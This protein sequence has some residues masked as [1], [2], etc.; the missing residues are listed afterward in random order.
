MSNQKPKPEE[1]LNFFFEFWKSTIDQT[2]LF[3]RFPW[4]FLDDEDEFEFIMGR[5]CN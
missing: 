4:W 3:S 1:E 2:L 5:D